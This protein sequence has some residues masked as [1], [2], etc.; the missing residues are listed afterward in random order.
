MNFINMTP[1]SLL[2]EM[3]D[4]N[5]HVFRALRD[6]AAGRFP[7][8]N[9]YR[10]EDQILLEM[11]L[12]GKAAEELSLMLEPQA[13]VL[14]EHAKKSSENEASESPAW[15]RRFELPFRVD[16]DKTEAKFQDGILRILLPKAE[17]PSLRHIAIGA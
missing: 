3:L 6:R 15:S 17:T 2:D 1:W 7:P 8:V 12:P 11:E 9:V 13:V 4:S 14:S 16:P 5:S 10:K